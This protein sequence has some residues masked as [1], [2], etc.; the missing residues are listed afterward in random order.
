VNQSNIIFGALLLAFI[1]YITMRGEL[2]IYMGFF[3][4]SNGTSTSTSSNNGGSTYTPT[5][6][7]QNVTGPSSNVTIFGFDTGVNLAN[8][9]KAIFGFTTSGN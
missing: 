5:N 3:V 8:V 1:V 9:D 4:P 7:V 2:P 6:P